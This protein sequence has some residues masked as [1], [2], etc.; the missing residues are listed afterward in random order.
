[1]R[2]VQEIID[3]ADQ[4]VAAR[5]D[6][7]NILALLSRQACQIEQI[8]HPEDRVQWCAHFMT[9]GRNKVSF[10]FARRFRVVLATVARGQAETHEQAPV[11]APEGENQQQVEKQQCCAYAQRDD[12]LRTLY[13]RKKV[14]DIGVNL[15]DGDYLPVR[16]SQ[17]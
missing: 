4:H 5:L 3:Q 11:G 2:E 9:D 17:R 15:E 16:V 10:C 6:C 7:L 13:L 12:A 8:G 14:R 1:M